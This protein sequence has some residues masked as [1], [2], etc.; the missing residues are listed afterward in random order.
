MLEGMEGDDRRRGGAGKMNRKEASQ[1]PSHSRKAEA[2]SWSKYESAA[3]Q[4]GE[5]AGGRGFERGR[6]G[7]GIR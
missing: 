3:T 5:T 6:R 7:K 2:A 1:M 4:R